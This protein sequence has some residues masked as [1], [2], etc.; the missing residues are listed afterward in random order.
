MFKNNIE[1]KSNEIAD[2]FSSAITYE[3]LS[4]DESILTNYVVTLNQISIPTVFYKKDAVCYAGGAIKVVSS[5][6]GATVAINSNGK[7]IIA[8]KI[9]NGEALFTDLEIDSYIV[10]IGEELKLINIT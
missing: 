1:Q 6:E 4:E 10:S 9:T 3:V 2:N 5:Q 8:K 7:T